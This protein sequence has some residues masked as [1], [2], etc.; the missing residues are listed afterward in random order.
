MKDGFSLLSKLRSRTLLYVSALALLV[1][2]YAL[3]P[4]CKEYSTWKEL[5]DIPSNIHAS[6]SLVLGCLLVFRTNTAYSRWW[7]ARTLWGGLVNASRNLAAKVGQMVDLPAAELAEAEKDIVAFCHA[8]KD[9]LRDGA[10]GKRL[11]GFDGEILKA[12]HLPAHLISRRYAALREWKK[13]GY[14]DGDELRVIDADLAKFLDICG[15]CE[16]IRNTRVVRSFRYFARQSVLVF[17]ITF[18][19][20]LVH[21]F[22]WWTIPVSM[23]AAYFMLGLEIV[24]EHI[25]EPFGFDEDDLDLDRICESIERSV[26]EIVAPNDELESTV[27]PRVAPHA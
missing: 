21:D 2:F 3:L 13:A 22:G 27:P 17:L 8:L 12:H 20:A 18:P 23:I 19:W 15:G 5:W 14:I 1:G 16:R 4:L 9:H 10:A 25:E 26:K 11:P 6:L 7:E 24:A